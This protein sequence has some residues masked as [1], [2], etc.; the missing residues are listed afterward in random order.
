MNNC[1]CIN[2]F[3]GCQN[4]INILIIV[5]IAVSVLSAILLILRK[6]KIIANIRKFKNENSLGRISNDKDTARSKEE[7]S[8]LRDSDE[9]K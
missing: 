9:F 1:C 7:K 3:S 6:S 5:F 4:G 8:I 2:F